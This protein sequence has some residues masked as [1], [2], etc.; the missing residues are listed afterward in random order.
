MPSLEQWGPATWALFHCFAGRMRV[1]SF[2]IVGKQLLFL[3]VQ[4]ASCLPCPECTGHAKKFF[5]SF[6]LSTIT[7]VEQLQN[8]LFHFHNRVN[9]RKGKAAFAFSSLSRYSSSHSSSHSSSSH[10]SF[11]LLSVYNIFVR[12]FHTKGDLTVLAESFHR[13]KVLAQFRHFLRLNLAKHFVIAVYY[14]PTSPFSLSYPASGSYGDAGSASASASAS[15]ASASSG[16]GSSSGSSG[17]GSGSSSGSS[18]ASLSS[19]AYTHTKATND[20]ATQTM[21]NQEDTAI[22][23]PDT[24]IKAPDTDAGPLVESEEEA[25]SHPEA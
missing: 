21:I 17:S 25:I 8:M 12:F 9:L 5:A 22:K 6:S 14:N 3:F 13:S 19:P 11:N 4:I 7:S 10:S 15:A 2:P 18:S 23:A 1:E 24:A 16:S 20:K